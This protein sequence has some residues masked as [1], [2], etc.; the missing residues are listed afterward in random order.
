[1]SLL[2]LEKEKEGNA[3][4]PVERKYIFSRQG[5]EIQGRERERREKKGG[6]RKEGGRSWRKEIHIFERMH[7]GVSKREEYSPSK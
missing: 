4:I 2:G 3:V 5:E 1:M 7:Q 6:E